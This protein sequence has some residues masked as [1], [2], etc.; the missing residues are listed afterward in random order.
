[1]KALVLL[2]LSCPVTCHLSRS[3]GHGSLGVVGVFVFN[4]SG[5]FLNGSYPVVTHPNFF[6]QNAAGIRL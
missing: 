3:V 1:M 2:S 4:R 5:V 6:S